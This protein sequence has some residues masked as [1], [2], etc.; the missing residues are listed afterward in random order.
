[1]RF[2]NMSA[3][4]SQNSVAKIAKNDLKAIFI[5]FANRK[6]PKTEDLKPISN[7]QLTTIIYNL[8]TTQY[9]R[10]RCT[11]CRIHP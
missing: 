1:M 8:L 3:V 5:I 7:P 10:N 4:S 9:A 11:S 6:R 2:L